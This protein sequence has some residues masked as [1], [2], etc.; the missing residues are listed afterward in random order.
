MSEKEKR[1]DSKLMTPGS[2]DIDAFI[3]GL[4]TEA[5]ARSPK[6]RDLIAADMS[7]LSGK[8]ITPRMLDAYTSTS[9]EQHRFPLA[10]APAFCVAVNDWSVARAICDPEQNE[11]AELG[12]QYLAH[13]RAADKIEQLE[14]RLQPKETK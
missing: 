14:K 5:I 10:F 9:K 7:E 8:K 3:R 1:T 11:L 12:R 2:Y 4:I 13:K 6:S